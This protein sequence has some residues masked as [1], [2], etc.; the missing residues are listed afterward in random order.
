[1][2]YGYTTV[3]I[4]SFITH[5]VGATSEVMEEMMEHSY[6]FDRFTPNTDSRPDTTGSFVH[7][8]KTARDDFVHHFGIQLVDSKNEL[9]LLKKLITT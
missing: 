3:R 7:L 9:N 5:V 8:S 1:M 6:R 4:N 2:L